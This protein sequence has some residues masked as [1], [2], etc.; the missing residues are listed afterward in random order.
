[1]PLRPWRGSP[2]RY[3]TPIPIAAGARV[4]SNAASSAILALR[5][6]VSATR[7]DV[8][9]TSASSVIRPFYGSSRSGS[10]SRVVGPSGARPATRSAPSS[11]CERRYVDR[12]AHR[13]IAGVG[14]VQVVLRQLGELAVG[15][16]LRAHVARTRVQRGRVKVFHAVEQPGRTNEVVKDLPAGVVPPPAVAPV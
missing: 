12:H 7:R 3:A 14:G 1:M 15:Q 6:G 5:L 4:R 11:G 2:E 16:E 13:V 9:T 8:A 10:R